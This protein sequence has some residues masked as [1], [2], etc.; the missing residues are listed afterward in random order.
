MA[1]INSSF[2]LVRTG[3]STWT[4]VHVGHDAF[5]AESQRNRDVEPSAVRASDKGGLSMF[6]ETTVTHTAFAERFP[7][8][9]IAMISLALFA[10]SL[11]VE[12]EWLRQ[13]GYYWR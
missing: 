4:A 12:V 1:T 9:T 3:S 10:V 7:R 11:T 13:A 6:A 2:S 8:L 5:G